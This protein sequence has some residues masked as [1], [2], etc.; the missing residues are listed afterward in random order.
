MNTDNISAENCDIW[1]IT[2]RFLLGNM[3]CAS[4]LSAMVA[5]PLLHLL[6]PSAKAAAGNLSEEH[7]THGLGSLDQ[8]ELVR[9]PN[10]CSSEALMQC[11]GKKT[12]IASGSDRGGERVQR[13]PNV[14]FQACG[15]KCSAQPLAQLAVL[16]VILPAG[17]GFIRA[18]G[19]RF[20]HISIKATCVSS[21]SSKTHFT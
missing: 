7:S 1:L 13:N 4:L 8:G 3:S 17:L 2:D 10:Q 14:E 12:A 20:P 11:N 5:G 18:A 6:F 16:P 19:I 15:W 9:K 21:A